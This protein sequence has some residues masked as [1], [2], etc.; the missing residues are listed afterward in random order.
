VRNVKYVVV[1]IKIESVRKVR[2]KLLNRAMTVVLISGMLSLAACGNETGET[3]NAGT[4][5]VLDIS[6]MFTDRDLSG[7]YKASESVKIELTGDSAQC[8][9]KKVQVNGGTITIT[10]E[11]TYVLSGKLENGCIVIEADN[12]A[13]KVQLVLNNVEINNDSGAAI[14]VKSC[15]KVFVTSVGNSSNFLSNGGNYEMI[16]ENHVD[17]A[18]FSKSDLCFNGSGTLMITAKAGHGVVTKD[19]LK[20]TDGNITVN[21]PEGHGFSGKDSV[22]IA[23]G[24]IIVNCG[25]DGIHSENA[26]DT[27]KGY[28][29]IGGGYLDIT[30]GGDGIAASGMVQV[31]TVELKILA[32]GGNGNKIT[33][34]NENGDAISCKGIKSTQDMVL[35]NGTFIIDSQDDAVHSNTNLI[36]N[37]GTYELATGDDGIHADETTKIAG[38]AVNILTSYEGIEGN[39]IYVSGG[40]VKMLTDDDG[41]N[42]AGG[43]DGGMGGMFGGDRFGEST[44]STVEI[45]GGTIYMNAAGDGLDSN[46]SLIVTGGAVYIS[47]PT[48]GANGSLDYTTT[49]QA[50]GGTVVALGSSRMAMNFDDSSTQGSV[51]LT[52]SGNAGAGTDI[53]VKDAEGN[54]IIQYTAESVFNS[55]LITSPDLQVGEAYTF[56]IGGSELEITL[57]TLINGSGN[58]MGGPGGMRMP[59]RMPGDMGEPS[60]GR[61]DRK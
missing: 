17:G 9:L 15:D 41:I 33:V 2:C 36:V 43:N 58:G 28:V 34:K 13:A 44:D 59:G 23:D 31:D 19:D 10:E 4:E 47:G 29:Y 48:N 12:D 1:R 61:P 30:S 25:K 18:L 27:A 16:D 24:N 52:A 40:Y 7:E 22:R 46:G 60:V 53:L 26:E 45:S 20:I 11:G 6:D 21:A 55:I 56:S 49:G 54:I 38:G 42:A 39:K 32:G 57:E 51:L 8:N 3:E 5:K 50:A 37:G 14:Y 35:N